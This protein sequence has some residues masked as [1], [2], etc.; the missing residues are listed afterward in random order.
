M[1]ASPATLA[2]DDFV[3]TISD[4]EDATQD[5]ESSAEEWEE[6]LRASNKSKRKRGVGGDD[7]GTNKGRL[8]KQRL[9]ASG[10]WRVKARH[11]GDEETDNDGNEVG[12]RED[13]EVLDTDFEF[14][15]PGLDPG[16]VVEELDAWGDDEAG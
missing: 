9:D 13:D 10:T 1:A 8:K 3:F 6:I 11:L 7:G 16:G 12:E 15:I 2:D 4:S 5:T 14:E